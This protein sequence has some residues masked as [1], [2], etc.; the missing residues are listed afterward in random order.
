MKRIVHI[1]AVLGLAILLIGKV[2][3]AQAGLQQDITH[4]YSLID[5]WRIDE[6]EEYSQSLARKYPNSGDVLFL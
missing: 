4:G 3:P 5:Q 1:A 6:A 2:A